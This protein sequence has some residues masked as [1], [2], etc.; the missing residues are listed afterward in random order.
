MYKIFI[1]AGEQSGDDIASNLIQSF[2]DYP[3]TLEWYGIGGE[4]MRQAGCK[5]LYP[6]TYIA[7]LGI[8][9]VV[10][11]FFLLRKIFKNTIKTIKKLNPDLI[12]TIDSPG[13]NFRLVK[14]LQYPAV[15]FVAPTVWAY[16]PKRADVVIK[17]YKHLFVLLPFELK[18]FP[19]LT[20]TFIGH[21]IMKNNYTMKQ[22]K[23]DEDIWKI[24]IMPGSRVQELSHLKVILPAIPLIQNQFPNKTIQFIILTLPHLVLKIQ[25]LTNSV[26]TVT[27]NQNILNEAVLVL[28]KSGT[29]TLVAAHAQIPMITFYKL[30]FITALILKKQLK[31]KF[32]NLCNI[33]N[34]FCNNMEESVPELIQDQ[35]SITNISE[36]VIK[37]LK[38]PIAYARQI[39][40]QNIS[41]NQLIGDMNI[42]TRQ[43][44]EILKRNKPLSKL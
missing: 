34:R 30:S 36:T 44:I 32:F 5:I 29:S 37:L 17:L 28:S 18:Y 15:H 13:F 2:K 12:I 3:I 21:P 14:K 8:W 7:I 27:D 9:E 42:A 10:K 20:T 4:A 31:I 1:I 22:H 24:V 38:D 19:H 33:I 11:N 40:F 26:I 25:N 41:L 35:F 43:I 6:Y 39:E 23:L 16:K